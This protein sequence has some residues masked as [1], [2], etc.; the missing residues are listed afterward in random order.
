MLMTAREIVTRYGERRLNNR[1]DYYSGRGAMMCDLNSALLEKLYQGI[2]AEHGKPAAEEFVTMVERIDVLSATLFLNSLYELEAR[3]WKWEKEPRR[4]RD[5]EHIEITDDPRPAA[6]LASGMASILSW[7]G[8]GS[9]RDDTFMIR[10]EFLQKHG[11][12]Q[13]VP[14]QVQDF[15]KEFPES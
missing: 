1:P 14:R 4:S 13:P 6:Q 2:L 11:R 7:E 3:K 5:A 15:M 9:T 12:E 8:G 10:A